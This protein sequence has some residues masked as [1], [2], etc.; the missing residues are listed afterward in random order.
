M[1]GPESVEALDGGRQTS[2]GLV[3]KTSAA[4][5]QFPRVERDAVAIWWEFCE[6][7]DSLADSTVN[8]ASGLAPSPPHLD[9]PLASS[10]F[11]VLAL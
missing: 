10:I 5:R 11:S 4:K 8:T 3:T 9:S 7:G 2:P 6:P 1:A